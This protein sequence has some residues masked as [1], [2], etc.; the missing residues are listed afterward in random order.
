M[1]EQ[2][3]GM[4][5]PKA[6]KRARG[7]N[8]RSN[9]AAKEIGNEIAAMA[10]VAMENGDYIYPPGS[11]KGLDSNNG[12][13]KN[14]LMRLAGYAIVNGGREFD[15]L[16][17]SKREFRQMVE[18]YRI[19]ANDP[20]FRK[21]QENQLLG[22]ILG[23]AMRL[24]AERLRY[25]PHTFTNREVIDT[26]GKLVGAANGVPGGNQ[27]TEDNAARLLSTLSESQR[28]AA[29]EGL[30]QQNQRDSASIEALER[31]HAA[32]DDGR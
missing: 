18:L 29:L 28:K 13:N 12:I 3:E 25:Y 23:D 9:Q 16:L 4:A 5:I 22:N 24:L 2:L 26:I 31:A 10:F 15:D 14:E 17:W 32:A 21:E 8:G 6:P 7:Q 20:L 1:G 27:E 30:K 19:R 11:H